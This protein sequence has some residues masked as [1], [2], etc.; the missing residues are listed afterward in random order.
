MKLLISTFSLLI[1][2]WSFALD[3]S[4]ARISKPSNTA[5]LKILN[6]DFNGLWANVTNERRMFTKCTILYKDN[7]FVVQMWGDCQPEDCDWG[8]RISEKVKNGTNKFELF[9]EQE[10]AE[11]EITYELFDEKL[12][13]TNQRRF[14]DNSVRQDYTLVEYFTKQ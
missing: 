10:F 5:L 11:S 2:F 12:K 4:K 1:L 13:V 7:S 8:E 3:S 6:A 14:K 9:W